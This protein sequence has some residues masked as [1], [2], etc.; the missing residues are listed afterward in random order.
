MMQARVL[1]VWSRHAAK[2]GEVKTVRVDAMQLFVLKITLARNTWC[3]VLRRH[4]DRYFLSH[5]RSLAP[6][7]C[8]RAMTKRPRLDDEL[9]VWG[10]KSP[11]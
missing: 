5:D 8:R 7:G 6:S 4:V 10:K 9:A 2:E 1:P 11:G 3:L